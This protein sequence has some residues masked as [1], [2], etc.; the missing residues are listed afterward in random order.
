MKLNRIEFLLMNNP[1]RGLIQQKYE[2][3]A[4]ARMTAIRRPDTVL[5]IGCGNGNGTRLI[6][7][8]FHP[9]RSMAID[10]DE[11][12][13][14]IASKRNGA[15]NISFGVMDASTLAFADHTVDAIFDFGIIHHIPNWRDCLSELKR[16]LKPGGELIMEDLSIDSFSGFPG[17][18][19]RPLLVHP[20]RRM[21][22]VDEFLA[23]AAAC[24]FAISRLRRSN[25][26][27]IIKFFR[28]VARA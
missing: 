3:P 2:F 15:G 17:R 5:E 24:G 6:E 23:E 21:Y 18:S 19:Y 25:P 8:H 9:K 7:T 12:M 26:L 27:G 11:R 4:L 16:V 28:M 22:S 20:Y 10:L 13:I 1:L 14:R